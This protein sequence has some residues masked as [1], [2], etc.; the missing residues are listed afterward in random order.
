MQQ[1]RE[2]DRLRVTI[3]R[4]AFHEP[5]EEMQAERRKGGR[6]EGSEFHSPDRHSPRE[7][8]GAGRLYGRIRRRVSG[9]FMAHRTRRPARPVVDS[10]VLI[11][12]CNLSDLV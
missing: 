2:A 1:P 11:E 12:R 3:R 7:S 6:V 5:R 10:G 9:Y 4:P 8:Y